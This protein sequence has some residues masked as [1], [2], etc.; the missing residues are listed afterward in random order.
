M[1]ERISRMPAHVEHLVVQLGKMGE[2]VARARS[3]IVLTLRR[4]SYCVPTNGFPRDG[5]GIKA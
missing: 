3:R 4:H 1:F 2:P 5:A